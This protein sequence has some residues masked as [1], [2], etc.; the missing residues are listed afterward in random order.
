MGSEQFGSKRIAAAIITAAVIVVA[1]PIVRDAV[2][3]YRVRQA[4][5]V[6]TKQLEVEARESQRHAAV[7]AYRAKPVMPA[8]SSAFPL[9]S[10]EECTGGYVVRPVASPAKGWEQV[11]EHGRPARCSGRYRVR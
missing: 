2:A 8:T 1:V 3:E 11:L 6:F 7:A 4:V 9:R 5:E 10:G